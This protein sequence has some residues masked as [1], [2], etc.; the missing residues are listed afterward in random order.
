MG[1]LRV[2]RPDESGFAPCCQGGE[3]DWVIVT[4]YGEVRQ[5]VQA[6]TTDE[7]R[8]MPEGQRPGGVVRLVNGIR[9]RL[10]PTRRP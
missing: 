9:V 3:S 8:C 10:F 5:T 6:W 7:W 2:V 1:V 4:P